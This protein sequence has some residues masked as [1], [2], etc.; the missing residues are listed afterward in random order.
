MITQKLERSLQL[1]DQSEI[2]ST[3]GTFD[4]SKRLSKKAKPLE[5]VSY[6]MK[7]IL[8]LNQESRNVRYFSIIGSVNIPSL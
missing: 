2:K 4:A 7:S 1:K 5:I 3:N 8:L 6:F